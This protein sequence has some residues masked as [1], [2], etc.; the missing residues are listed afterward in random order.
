MPWFDQRTMCMRQESNSGTGIAYNVY[1]ALCFQFVWHSRDQPHQT[2]SLELWPV[3][4]ARG[5]VDLI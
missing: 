1:H 3:Y 2:Q 5:V 4:P